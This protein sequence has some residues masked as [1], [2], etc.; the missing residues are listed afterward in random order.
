MKKQILLASAFMC[1]SWAVGQNLEDYLSKY[2]Q[3]NGR[4]YLQP[5]TDAFSADLNSGLFHQAFVSKNGFQLYI[6]VVGQVAVIPDDQKHFQA[7]TESNLYAPEGPHKVPT[8]FGP[9]EVVVVPVEASSGLIDYAFPAGFNIDY[10]PL[11]TPQITIGSLLGTDLTVR[12]V[13]LD[14]DDLGDLDLFGWGIRHNLI[15]YLPSL[16]VDLAFG[17]YHQSFSIGDYMDAQSNLFSF[18]GSYPVS[19]LTIYGGL[20]L[21]RSNMDVQYTYE[22]EEDMTGSKEEETIQFD[23]DGANNLR[24]TVGVTFNL[25]PVKINTDYNLAG[26]STISAGVGLGINQN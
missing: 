5:F 8:V 16:P 25:G 17:Y 4:K 20:G 21:E 9:N 6:G 12:Y 7:Y 11:A 14:L 23:L 1:I 18:Q 3:E 22:R 10:M 24:F 13:T 15:Q 2:T 26:Q 19:L